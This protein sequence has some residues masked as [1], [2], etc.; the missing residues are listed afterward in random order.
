MKLKP[1]SEQIGE[2]W[3]TIVHILCGMFLVGLYLL[4]P[5]L[6]I[7]LFIGFYAYEITQAWK[8]G[9]TGWMEIRHFL[10]GSFG[11][12]IVVAILRAL[13]VI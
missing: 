2:P 12:A 13:G 9:D 5:A 1:L 7:T 6:A 10:C 3:A 8:L 11:A 4:F